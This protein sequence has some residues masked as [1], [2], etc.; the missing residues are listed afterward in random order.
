DVIDRRCAKPGDHGQ[1]R[2]ICQAADQHR[3]GQHRGPQGRCVVHGV[4][5]LQ[6]DDAADRQLRHG[7]QRRHIHARH[8]SARATDR[9]HERRQHRRRTGGTRS[10]VK[11]ADDE[12]HC[13]PD[14]D[15]GAACRQ[16]S[17]RVLIHARRQ[18]AGGD[19]RVRTSRQRRR[20]Q[21]DDVYQHGADWTQAD[22]GA[23][24][25]PGVAIR[26]KAQ[27]GRTL[28]ANAA[29]NDADATINYQWEESSDGGQTWTNIASNRDPDN[30]QSATVTSAATGAVLPV[31]PGL[32]APSSLTTNEDGTVV[33][34]ITVTPFNPGDPIDVTISGIP[35]DET[36]TD[37]LGDAFNGGAPITLG[38]AQINS[39]LTLDAGEPVATNLTV[40]ATN[41][42]GAT[43]STR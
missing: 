23:F 17:D 22:I 27:E 30:P 15:R 36:L 31:A 7:A 37:G 8:R 26:G 33:V 40:T 14:A 38:L 1:R 39:G 35:S 25:N 41:E 16:R 10:G 28:T 13:Q 29:T 20:H 42:A 3:S 21:R 11:S 43:D 24:T 19:R 18:H 6:P 2:S 32:S 34:P 4:F 9:D 12:H 5:D